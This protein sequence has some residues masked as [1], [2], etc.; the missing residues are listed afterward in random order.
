MSSGSTA[1]SQSNIAFRTES[2]HIEKSLR[3]E[4]QSRKT[5][6]PQENK[7]TEA[8]KNQKTGADTPTR[9]SAV[10]AKTDKRSEMAEKKERAMQL[11]EGALAASKQINP[12]EYRV[13]T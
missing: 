6:Y 7:P 9:Q 1:L 12:I 2:M 8:G 3:Q 4:P 5:S 11:L 10:V 13:L